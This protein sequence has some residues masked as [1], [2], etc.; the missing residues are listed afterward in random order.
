MEVALQMDVGLDERL[1]RG[2]PGRPEASDGG[3]DI[4]QGSE[5][6]G[7]AA[8]TQPEMREAGGHRPGDQLDWKFSERSEEVRVSPSCSGHCRVPESSLR[9]C[10]DRHRGPLLTPYES[11]EGV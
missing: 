7:V 8:W 4:G 10:P 5:H 2:C 3:G 6:P 11:E 1:E 9:Q